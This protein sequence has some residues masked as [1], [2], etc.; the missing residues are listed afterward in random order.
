MAQLNPLKTF[1]LI[2]PEFKDVKDS[3]VRAMLELCEPLVSKKR[4]G[5]STI[6]PSRFLLP[7]A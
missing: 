4:F 1:R 7:T 6:R 3:E 5:R 2:A